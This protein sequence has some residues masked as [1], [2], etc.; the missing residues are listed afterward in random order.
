ML[1]QIGGV[2][3]ALQAQ[4]SPI[5]TRLPCTAVWHPLTGPLGLDGRPR[6][7]ERREDGTAFGVPPQRDG[8]CRP[9]SSAT[10]QQTWLPR[11]HGRVDEDGHCRCHH[12]DGEAPKEIVRNEVLL[13]R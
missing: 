3:L 5:R 12:G 6:R 9:R 4:A 13:I 8:C 10:E 7:S 1:Y 2:R 11:G